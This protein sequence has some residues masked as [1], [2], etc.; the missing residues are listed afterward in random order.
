MI[1][2][3][4]ASQRPRRNLLM[5][6]GPT[7]APLHVLALLGIA[8]FL[9]Y[10]N[11]FDSAWHLDDFERIVH[12]PTVQLSELSPDRLSD[13][14]TVVWR[15]G[16]LQRPLAFTS[17]AV[18]WYFGA[19]HPFG[20]HIFNTTIHLLCAFFLF[21][22]FTRLFQTPR[23]SATCTKEQAGFVS[24]LAVFL[25]A[26]NPIQT[27][28]TTYVIQ[29]MASMSAMFFILAIYFY[30]CGR[31]TP[32]WIEKFWLFTGCLISFAA[33]FFSKEN[34]ATLP[35]I[36]LL[37]EAVFFQD[38]SQKRVRVFFISLSLAIIIAGVTLGA[39]LFFGGDALNVL[40]YE[41]R[42]FTP[43]QR[44]LS[45]P[46]ALMLYLSLILYPVPTRLSITHDFEVSTAL[47]QPW[48]TL[49]SM[50]AV[51]GL[52]V[53]AVWRIRRWP[54][55][56][57]AILFFF[58]NHAI[59]SGIIPLELVF[60]H[61]NYL[62]S[63]FIFLAVA[64][65]IARTMAHFR[66]R[67]RVVTVGLWAFIPL[68]VVG[69][70]T[71]TYIRNQ[72]WE[73]EKTLW[74]DAAEK[75]PG[76]SRPSHMLAANYYDRIGD[77]D[78]S[79]RLYQLSLNL[80]RPRIS[81]E[82]LIYNNMGAAFYAR[83]D[84]ASAVKLWTKTIDVLPESKRGRFHLA[85]ALSRT[86]RF[87]EALAH[88]EEILKQHPDYFGPCNLKGVILIRQGNY[89]EA[90]ASLR[91]SLKPGAIHRPALINLG[92]A[93]YYLGDHAKAAVFLQEALKLNP[94]DRAAFAWLA[95]NYLRAGETIAAD[96]VIVRLLAT[97]PAAVLKTWLSSCAPSKFEDDEIV[98]P[99]LDDRFL[100]RLNIAWLHTT[101][102]T[103]GTLSASVRQFDPIE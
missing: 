53:L 12:N 19:D 14:S 103:A 7:T 21:L 25:W 24:L 100:G 37:V 36:L 83:G 31:M 63:M 18:N 57:F 74:E 50:A 91:Q 68:L 22:V 59:E 84:Y 51:V 42:T 98:P 8:V 56:S 39:I 15:N 44:L 34:G 73:S 55:V 54:M 82:A 26:L 81:H 66:D 67:S 102:D 29:R 27:Q 79:M 20:Y 65:A 86:N 40:K 96:E 38:L 16:W 94:N 41:D 11:T 3:F 85:V 48:T 76:E 33:S 45:Q 70:G 46:R 69:L 23:L 9:S 10:G 71:G 49:P 1:L 101:G 4:Y 5:S 17:I 99:D 35:L 13:F 77:F 62:P 92:V 2:F 60:E 6:Q 87:D 30:L 78:T 43:W 80:R 90:L 72:A 89:L 32:R 95:L 97:A 61:R 52:I 64:A 93:Y 58:V 28:A 75:A 47:L 88:L